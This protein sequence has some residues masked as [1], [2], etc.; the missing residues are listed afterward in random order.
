MDLP[1]YLD[2]NATTPCDPRVTEEMLPFFTE[3][4]GNAAS[5]NHPFGWLAEEAVDRAREQVAGLI[6][7]SPN[8][9]VFTSGA[10]EADNLAIKGV[11]AAAGGKGH[12]ITVQTE[13][14][15]VLDSCR[16]MEKQGAQVTYLPVNS[17]GLIDTNEL[18]SSIRPDTLLIAIMYANNETGVIQPMDKISAIAK[19]HGI[20]FFTDGVQATG[21]IPVDV[22]REG[23]HL[24]ALSA[25]KLYGPKGIGALYVSQNN[26][27]VSLVQQIDGGGHE[28]HMRSG[29]LNVPGIVGFGKAAEIAGLEVNSFTE[30]TIKLRNK[31]ES[32]LLKIDDTALNGH[33]ELRLPHVTNIAFGYTEGTAL[34][35]EI[36]KKVACSSGSACSSA[37]TD[38]SH[39]L[40]SMGLSNERG[41][42]SVRFSLGRFTTEE[43]IDRAIEHV[44]EVL[45]KLRGME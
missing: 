30:T 21:K 16:S 14:R 32:E 27:G 13:H 33:K 44:T 39:V 12:I 17:D 29:T 34:L 42:S 23:I 10:T 36:N 37:S 31:L 43:E 11:F 9:I 2:N 3:T 22:K 7:A 24:M 20:L 40:K 18:E 28:R 8:E 25:H 15:A 4:F 1:I 5:H 19:K 26:P 45:N 38:P 6:G 41:R 35:R